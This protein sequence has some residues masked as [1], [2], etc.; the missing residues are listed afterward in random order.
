MATMTLNIYKKD[1]KNE[2]EK[3]YSAESYD[4]M[5]GTVE[6]I[7]AIID[8]DKMNN[9]VEIATMVVKSYSVL[10]P[11]IKDVFPGLT[12]E[13]MTRIKVKELIPTFVQIFKSIIESLSLVKTEKN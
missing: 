4:L 9:D 7:M 2:I 11:F 3:T 5:L 12:D 6:D 8:F 1:N 10:K 13:E